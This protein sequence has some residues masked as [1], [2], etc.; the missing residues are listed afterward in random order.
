[1]VPKYAPNPFVIMMNNPWALERKRESV[2]VSM[3]MDPEI[4][5]KSKAIPYTMQDNTM[6]TLPIGTI[7]KAKNPYRK[8]QANKANN[9]TFFIPNFFKKNGILKN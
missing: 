3:Y 4:K 2:V 1:M 7:P 9:M 5:K 8:T 6:N